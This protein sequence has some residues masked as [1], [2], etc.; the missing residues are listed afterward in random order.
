MLVL[1]NEDV[2]SVLTVEDTLSSLEIAYK[3]Y[4][5]KRAANRERTHTYF[6]VEDARHPGFRFRFKSQEGGNVSSGVPVTSQTSIQGT[7]E[8]MVGPPGM[9]SSRCL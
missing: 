8:A 9:L 7:C 2:Q 5:D 6:P 1:S 4:A 3:E